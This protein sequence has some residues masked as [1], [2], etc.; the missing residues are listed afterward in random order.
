M[1]ERMREFGLERPETLA[2][3]L[4]LKKRY[5]A[6]AAYLAGGT[7][8]FVHLKTGRAD[9][10]CLIDISAIQGMAGV[11]LLND[12]SVR[13][14]AFTR[15]ADVERAPLVKSRYTALCQ[16]AGMLGSP[17][18]RNLATIGGNICNAAPS[19]DLNIP[20]M[21][22]DA[23]CE[24]YGENG[25]YFK[26]IADIFVTNGKNSLADDI[27]TA[28]ILP[29]LEAPCAFFY[30]KHCV[31]HNMDLAMVG[32]SVLLSMEAGVV[33]KVGISLGSVATTVI[34]A[35]KAAQWLLGKPITEETAAMAG[36]IAMTQCNP[37]PNSFRASGAYRREMV[38]A[39]LRM[40]L[41]KGAEEIKESE[42]DEA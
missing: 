40:L 22:L 6:D 26:P 19:G 39:I 7:D 41:I 14:G 27:L 38:A 42:R 36:D 5:G 10:A 37:N 29:P 34:K 31:R 12:G 1:L 8:V 23:R 15:V 4:E 13:I 21:A 11:T 17:Q 3:A 33:S 16:A 9:Y 32:V 30:E 25:L 28:V 35:D 24:V 2:S 20:L 18:I